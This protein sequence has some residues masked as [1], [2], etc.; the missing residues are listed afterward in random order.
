MLNATESQ[1]LEMFEKVHDGVGGRC[2]AVVVYD[3]DY[4]VEAVAVIKDGQEA[5]RSTL[6]EI[7][8]DLLVMQ[9]IEG[10]V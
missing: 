8:F 9:H 1:I 2:H 10:S 4:N 6:T 7:T 5:W 3:D